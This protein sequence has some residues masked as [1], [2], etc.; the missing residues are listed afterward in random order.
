MTTEKLEDLFEI[1]RL[2]ETK[3]SC[4]FQISEDEKPFIIVESWEDLEGLNA[5]LNGFEGLKGSK[6]YL[7]EGE[8]LVSRIEAANDKILKDPAHFGHREELSKLTSH[9]LYA[10]FLEIGHIEPIGID[11]FDVDWGFSDESCL[12]GDCRRHLR[13][14][15][16]SYSWVAPTFLDGLGHICD[17]CVGSGNYDGEILEEYK[18]EQ[19]ALPQAFI[20]LKTLSQVNKDSLENGWYGGQLDTPEPIIKAFNAANIDV[21]FE[22]FPSQFMLKFDVYVKD[23]DLERAEAL[24]ADTDTTLP[25]DPAEVIKRQLEGLKFS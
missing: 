8:S 9:L 1:I 18:N 2:R 22:V 5:H 17:D 4:Y 23:E 14:S 24:L 3:F 7:R 20:K 11:D 13:T 15:P 25:Y 10:Q 16:D 12:C 19:K 6:P 21:W